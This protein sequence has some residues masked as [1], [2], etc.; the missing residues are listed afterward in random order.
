M[1]ENSI[2]SFSLYRAFEEHDSS[3]GDYV[4]VIVNGKTEIV[5][6]GRH[7]EQFRFGDDEFPLD[8][9]HVQDFRF[10]S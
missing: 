3:D 8:A 1:K 2:V 5:P 9:P 10:V 7:N 6:E 4:F